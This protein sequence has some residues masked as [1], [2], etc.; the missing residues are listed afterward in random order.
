MKSFSPFPRLSSPF[1]LT[2]FAC[3]SAPKARRNSR[4][5]II[6]KLWS[7]I[8][9]REHSRLFEAKSSW[10][11]YS[12]NSSMTNSFHTRSRLKKTVLMTTHPSQ[13]GTCACSSS[14]NRT[15][16]TLPPGS[17]QRRAFRI[18]RRRRRKDTQKSA[19]FHLKNRRVC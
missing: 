1:L 4:S 10:F 5:L 9:L 15:Y 2:R 14:S 3:A 19:C 13:T 16:R 6:K 17:T 11:T 7:L 8:S 12:S 18:Q